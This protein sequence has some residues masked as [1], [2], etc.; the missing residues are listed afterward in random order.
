MII[1]I[2]YVKIEKK[3]QKVLC[4]DPKGS[5]VICVGVQR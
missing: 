1:R 3:L 2:P 4:P 5:R